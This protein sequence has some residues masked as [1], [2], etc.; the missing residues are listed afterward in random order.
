MAVGGWTPLTMHV[1]LKA[2]E[3]GTGI[4]CTFLL[5]STARSLHGF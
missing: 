3:Q 2:F 4:Q 5:D 1:V